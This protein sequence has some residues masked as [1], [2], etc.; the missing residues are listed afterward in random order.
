VLALLAAWFLV[1]LLDGARRTAPY[2]GEGK[3]PGRVWLTG[4][5]AVVVTV[6]TLI[7]AYGFTSIYTR[8][9]TRIAA[10]EWIY[11]NVPQGS[12]V[13][14]ETGWDDGLPL[15]RP[16][17]PYPYPDYFIGQMPLI[18]VDPATVPAD[19][20]ATLKAETSL[21][22]TGE[23]TREK[24]Y[25]RPDPSGYTYPGVLDKLDTIEYYFISSN[26]QYDS[27]TRLPM[28]FPAVVNFYD[29]LFSGELGF[30]R[31]A[32][33]TSYPHFL[34][35]PLPDQGAEEAWHVYDHNR[36][37]IWR[38]TDAYSR[39][40]AER[41]ILGDVDFDNIVQL[42]PKD[43]AGW[44]GNL[45]FSRAEREIYSDGGTW[46]R[47]FDRD[48]WQN[49]APLVAW[50][51]ALQLFGLIALP[52]LRAVAGGLPARG[53]F[54]AKALGLL[55]ATWVVWMIASAR[56]LPFTTPVIALS[57][58][59]VALG[60]L[61]LVWREAGYNLRAIPGSV[62]GWWM[63]DLR[64]LLLA[65]AVFWGFFVLVLAVRF[66]NPDLWHQDLG[67]EKPMDFA[68]LNA[69]IKS[70][71]F[72][73]MD[74]WFAGG[75]INYYYYGFII[76]AVL[77]KFTGVIPT[78]AYNLVIPTLFSM[79]ATGVFGVALALQV[80]LKVTD[81]GRMVN[82][83][84]PMLG[85][86][87]AAALFVGVLGNLGEWKVLLDN[88]SNLSTMQ[89][90]SGIPGLEKTVK[91][92]DGLVRGMILN[93]QAMPGRMEWPYWNPTR[94]IPETINEFPWFTFLYAD[95]HAHM[96]ALPYTVLAIGLALAFLRATPREGFISEAVRL[97]LM[98]LVLGALWPINTWDFPTYALVAFA[99]L[100]LREWRR[101]GKITVR[102]FLSVAWRW[103]L[104]V[105]LARLLFQPFHAA[106]GSAYTSVERW[107]GTRT[108]L[109]DFFIVHGLF[110]LAIAFALFHDFAFGK[111]HN[112]VVRL[113]RPGAHAAAA[114][115]DAAGLLPRPATAAVADGVVLRR[116]RAGADLRRGAGRAEGGH[117]AD[118][119]RL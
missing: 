18:G 87:L 67:G 106:Y 63:K 74:P 43:A 2:A 47:I 52:Y 109:P 19:Q 12:I 8:P 116:A 1:R 82:F 65:E 11:D 29:A 112:G 84:R 24:W 73:P 41:L 36:V 69:V 95:L 100:G 44:K 15:S 48:G 93:G 99:G 68:Y 102:G 59:L 45:K 66:A 79:M 94:T 98:G 103:A 110:L 39:E 22:I 53:Y 76:V 7:Y 14:N 49:K 86:A 77:T 13:A 91:S 114:L 3:I 83:T 20:L 101:D 89:F 70:N 30:E 64:L 35:I 107:Q 40:N 51:L 118:E 85:I 117:R 9:H 60:G 50:V 38:K 21:D 37:Q 113:A 97:G 96:M 16:D 104:L 28:R 33:F 80:P 105:V 54:F 111:G 88:L 75:Y 34:G 57:V 72:P 61:F 90:S 58:L 27:L 23:D 46:S 6:A 55:M 81:E 108:T 26:R 78:V 32:E 119:H 42:W 56:W 71:F 5:L 92:I 62:R 17:R 115:P 25:G 10:S 4:G 31:V